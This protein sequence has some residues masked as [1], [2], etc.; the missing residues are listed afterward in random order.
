M[1][2]SAAVEVTPSS[3][4]NSVAV[5]VTPSRMFN[6]AEVEVT[7]SSMFNSVAV[8]VTPSRIFSSS[9]VE[10]IAVALAAARTGKVPDWFGKFIVLS[11]VGSTTPRVVSEASAVAPSRTKPPA[12]TVASPSCAAYT[13]VIEVFPKVIVLSSSPSVPDP[14]TILFTAVASST[15]AWYPTITLLVPEVIA[16]LLPSPAPA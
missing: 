6:S 2:N 4:F 12:Y 15:P 8:E 14:I 9:G 1:F 10:V 13:P 11:A 3:M 7:P 5:E 16:V